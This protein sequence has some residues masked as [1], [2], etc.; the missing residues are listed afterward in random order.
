MLEFVFFDARPRQRFVDFLAAH[1]V[2]CELSVGDDSLGVAIDEDIDD[3][4]LAT[5]EAFYDEMMALDQAL[6]E[7]DE[8]FAGHQA[9]GVVVNLS[10]GERVYARVDQH[11]LARVMGVLTPQELGELVNAI[12]DAVENPDTRPLCK[13]MDLPADGDG[14]ER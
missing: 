12:A 2:A 10:S 14:G 7:S 13:A 3:G 4:L 5:I 6:F 11:L 1:D 9:A 8:E